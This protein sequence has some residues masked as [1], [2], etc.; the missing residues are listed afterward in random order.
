MSASTWLLPEF[1][2][3]ILPAEARGLEELR[4]K[5]LDLYQQS[6]FE[7]VAPPLVEF[8]ESLFAGQ[9]ADLPKKTV[10]VIDQLSGRTMG[11]RPDIT[12][13][14]SR[15]DAHLLNRAGVTRLC[16]C[17]VAFHSVPN[18]LIGDREL[19]Q[20]GAEIFGYAGSEAD[21][22]IIS[23]A[24]Q[25]LET[26]GVHG[27][28]LDLNHPGI[29]RA[30]VAAHPV[31]ESEVDKLNALVR[32]KAITSLKAFLAELDG[33]PPEIQ[34]AL[35]VLPNLYG[36]A[37]TLEV[38]RSVLPKLPEIQ[39]ALDEL[40]AIVKRF[41][42]ASV[43]LADISGYDYHSGISFALYAEGWHNALVRGG[44]YDRVAQAYGRERPATGFSLN[45]RRLVQGLESPAP[46]EAIKTSWSDDEEHLD[47]I[48]QLRQ[49]GHIVVQVFPDTEQINEE[50]IFTREL[51]IENDQWVL[52]S[53]APLE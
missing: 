49:Q 4:R 13:Q 30:L 29:M 21:L 22:Q 51:V 38:A 36:G 8:T 39:K 14:V 50:Y 48:Q 20:I 17:G 16:Y 24:Y 43:D 52:K 53:I 25:T 35:L 45:L 33:V 1:I 15:I 44:R 11:I 26:A 34:Q 10:K 23:L 6:G 31:L 12:P 27:A 2:S 28:K 47:K 41:P 46:N 42:S 3:D 7:L 37:D 32:E 40:E 19:V 18:D 9:R 5:L